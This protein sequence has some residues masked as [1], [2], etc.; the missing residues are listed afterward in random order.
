M[1]IV[2]AITPIKPYRYLELMQVVNQPL[3]G[4]IATLQARRRGRRQRRRT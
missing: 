1:K 2:L 4:C 3:D